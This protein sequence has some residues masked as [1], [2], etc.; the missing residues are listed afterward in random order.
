MVILSI[1]TIFGRMSRFFV[2]G[3]GSFQNKLKMHISIFT[4]IATDTNA[5]GYKPFLPHLAQTIA[6]P[7]LDFAYTPLRSNRFSDL[8]DSERCRIACR[9]SLMLQLRGRKMDRVSWECLK[10]ALKDTKM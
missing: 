5:F 1:Y 8:E 7:I 6:P 4:M 10:S 9:V 2:H 3:K